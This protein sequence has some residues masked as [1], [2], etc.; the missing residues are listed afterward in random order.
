[1]DKRSFL[2]VSLLTLSFFAINHFFT[3][4]HKAAVTITTVPVEKIAPPQPQIRESQKTQGEE[5]Y[6]LENEYQQIVFSNIGG[7]ISEINLPFK[8]RSAKSTISPIEF[9]RHLEENAPRNELF[10]LFAAY[11][12]ENGQK[13]KVLPG[14]SMGY[15]PMLR[16]TLLKNWLRCCWWCCWPWPWKCSP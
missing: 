8:A 7:A 14:S 4:A 15:Y 11:K 9:D 12:W 6:I 16:R 1:M 13:T 3:P 2:F 10:P 5:F